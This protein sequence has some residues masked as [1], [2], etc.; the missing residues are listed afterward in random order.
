[1]RNRPKTGVTIVLVALLFLWMAHPMTAQTV[2]P[3]KTWEKKT[4]AD[5]GMDAEK[6][7]AF[8]NYVGGRGCV[9][10]HGYMVYTWGDH[11][12]RGDVASACKPWFS[13]FLFRAVE[14]EESRS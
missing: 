3:G 11:K 4:P 5:L 6:L 12:R 10:R 2:C 14:E 1:M 8:S 7:L 13:H 9:T